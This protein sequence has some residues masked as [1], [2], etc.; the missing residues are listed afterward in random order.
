MRLWRDVLGESCPATSGHTF[1]DIS[2]NTHETAIACLHALGIIGGDS[3]TAYMPSAGLRTAH[4]SVLITRILEKIKPG[5]CA[6]RTG[7]EMQ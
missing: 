3:P 5:I 6:G 4:T 1:T 2:G 7:D